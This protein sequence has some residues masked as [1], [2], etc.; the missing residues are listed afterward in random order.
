LRESGIPDAEVIYIRVRI[1]D[2]LYDLLLQRVLNYDYGSVKLTAFLIPYYIV[3]EFMIWR[4][5]R[6]EIKAGKFALVHRLDP[7]TVVCLGHRGT[8]VQAGK[9]IRS[10]SSDGFTPTCPSHDRPIRNQRPSL[11]VPPIPT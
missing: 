9:R 2:R 3:Y 5:L 7:L 10:A 4:R 1:F 6:A 11:S 8:R